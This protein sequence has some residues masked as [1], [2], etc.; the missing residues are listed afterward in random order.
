MEGALGEGLNRLSNLDPS[1]DRR[2]L[3]CWFSEEILPLG[4]MIERL[5]ARYWRDTAEI[6][7]LRQEVYIRLCQVA[8]RA[9]PNPVRPYVILT[10]RNLVIDRLRQKRLVSIETMSDIES[11]AIPDD[12]PT[13]EQQVIAQQELDRIQRALNALPQRCREI[14][15]MRKI[16]GVS[17][18]DIARKMGIKEQT[19]ETQVVRGMK[20]IG[21]S[22][23]VGRFEAA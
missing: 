20:R 21:R 6:E 10:A 5:I 18:R 9:R 17:Q 1:F 15:V 2:S 12:Q 8:K 4:P 13:P 19:V 7:D 22:D 16:L 23:A 14:I 3:D 11:L